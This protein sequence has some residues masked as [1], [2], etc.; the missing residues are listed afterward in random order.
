MTNKLDLNEHEKK[1]LS[2]WHGTLDFYA[3][4]WDAT[5]DSK[6]S[7]YTQ[8]FWYLLVDCVI[9]HWR[10]QPLTV[11][12]ASKRMKVGSKRTREHRIKIAE[13]DDLLEKRQQS[14]DR[15]EIL[16]IPTAKLELKIYHHLKR[17]LQHALDTL[18]EI[19][20]STEPEMEK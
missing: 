18:S 5:F 1:M 13:L 12:G 20:L 2:L 7:Y 3:H 4:D 19:Q 15:R 14:D 10:G 8:E 6:N 16:L 17:T 9:H 11:G